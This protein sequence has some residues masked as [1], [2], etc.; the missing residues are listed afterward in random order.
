MKKIILLLF[1]I[2]TNISFA[3]NK[4]LMNENKTAPIPWEQKITDVILLEATYNRNLGEFSEIYNKAAG[5]YVSY[6]KYMG[7][8][9]HLILRSGYTGY[10]VTFTAIPLQFGGRYYVL[11]DRF[12]P[13]FS[14]MNGINII[15]QD[16]NIAGAEDKQT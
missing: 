8:S 11:N 12:M 4:L 6:G 1:I 2:T 7:K 5:F 16:Q 13:Y 14:F 3:Q 15:S 10:S 9:Y